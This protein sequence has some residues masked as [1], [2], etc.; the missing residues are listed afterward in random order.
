MLCGARYLFG[1]VF[2]NFIQAASR[3]RVRYDVFI[4]YSLRDNG[5]GDGRISEFVERL[6]RDFA[7]AFGRPLVPFFDKDE[8]HGM[9][10]WRD[11]IL[12]SLRQSQLLI[13]CL[14][15]AYLASEYCQ[16]EFVE[17]LKKEVARG[18]IGEGVAPITFIEF[19]AR[20]AERPRWFCRGVARGA[21]SPAAV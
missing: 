11:R 4:S 1:A 9:D 20:D 2:F 18:F 19:P 6:R 7:A 10:D 5:Q 15:P 14:T 3:C 17:Y 21:E 13:A 12:K 8:I 16:W